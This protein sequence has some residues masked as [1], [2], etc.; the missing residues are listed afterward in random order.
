MKMLSS[1]MA[2]PLVRPTVTCRDEAP[3]RL[4]LVVYATPRVQSLQLSPSGLLEQRFSSKAINSI[5]ALF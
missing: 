2:F 3:N 5:V 4:V 1:G